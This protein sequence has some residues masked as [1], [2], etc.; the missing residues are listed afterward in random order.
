[1]KKK[2]KEKWDKDDRWDQDWKGGNKRKE[3]GK[4][5]QDKRSWAPEAYDEYVMQPVQTGKYYICTACGLGIA[6]W[7]FFQNIFFAGLFTFFS[8]PLKKYHIQNL[9]KEQ[10]S[11]LADQFR[12]LLYSISASAAAGRQLR[13][14]LLEAEENLS[15][16]YER[17]A[18]MMRE[19]NQMGRRMREGR[20]SEEQ[21]LQEF[22]LRSKV[23]DIE[24]FVE[25]CLICR[26]TGGNL[27]KMVRKASEVIRDKMEIQ[28][29]IR[30]LT[31][32]KRLEIR[33]LTAL[34]FLV[35][36]FLRVTSPDYFTIM[37]QT[38]I[39]H[40]LMAL[41]LLGIGIAYAISMK[42]I[43]IPV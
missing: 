42:L 6:A 17:S 39:G 12:D 19:L 4:K 8:I 3:K 14:A 15:M 41:S 24:N 25:V 9:A 13:E 40:I 43:R 37:D 26:R 28:R 18:P 11:Q 10:Q 27:E 22:A 32:Q 5:Q 20:E 38:G 34:P 35:I 31:A 21:L 36:L 2:W 7:L 16:I 23:E 29:E 33:L 1:M 30:M